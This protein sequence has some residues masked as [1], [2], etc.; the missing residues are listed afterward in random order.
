MNSKFNLHACQVRA[1]INNSGLC[2]CTCDTYFECQLTPL[3]VKSLLFAAHH[4]WSLRG[5]MLAR[6]L[7]ILYPV[8]WG[9]GIWWIAPWTASH[10]VLQDTAGCTNWSTQHIKWGNVPNHFVLNKGKLNKTKKHNNNECLER[11][12][13]TG[14]KRLHVLYKYI[15][16][17]VKIQRIQHECTHTCTHIH[18]LA[19][20]GTEVLILFIILS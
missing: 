9:S 15:I 19:H 13:R 14:P 10:C 2:C 11:L 20:A 5:F 8:S 7:A 1:T 17:I 6:L 4:L 3:Y 18:R 12:T 16:F